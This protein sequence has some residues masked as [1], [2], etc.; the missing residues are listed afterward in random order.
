MRTSQLIPLILVTCFPGFG[1]EVSKISEL[2]CRSIIDSNLP[3]AE[4]QDYTERRVPLMPNVSTVAEWERVAREMRED[5]LKTVV[6]RGKAAEWRKLK[7][8]VEWLGEIPGG[9][10]YRIRK[11]RYEAV[12]GLWIPAVLYEPE[13]LVGKAPVSL[14]V[15]GHEGIG[16][17]VPYKQIRCINQARRG[18]IALNPEWLGMGQLR[19]TNYQHYRMNQLDLCGTSGLAPFYLAMARGLDILLA[20]K[21]ADPARVAVSGLS[22]GG[23]QTI[24][25]SSLDTRVTLANPVAGYSSFRT[26]A[27]HLSDLGDSE[28]TPCDLG[29]VTDYAHLTAMMAPRP[30][31]LTFNAKDSCCFASP[32]AIG[33]LLEAATPIFKLYGREDAL[34]VHVNFHPGDHNFGQDNREAFYRMLGTFFCSENDVYTTL[35]MPCD[36]EVKTHE[37]L[38]VDLPPNNGNFNSIALELS[39]ELPR[40]S[41]LPASKSAAERWQE[42]N[43]PRLREILRARHSRATAERVH[44]LKQDGIEAVLW[45]FRVDDQWTVP[46]IELRTSVPKGTT[47]LV[48]DHGRRS[49][50][51]EA[52]KL[53][54]DGQ[55]VLAVDP[56]Y[57][58][59]SKIRSHDFLFALLLSAVG[60]RPLGLQASQVA[61]IAQWADTH[62]GPV[63]LQ[64]VGPRASTFALA[65]AALEPKVSALRL[66]GAM[67]SLKEIIEQNGSV[68]RTPELFCFGL[69]EAFDIKHITALIAPRP[70][71]FVNASDRVKSELT[72]LTGW[73][74]IFGEQTLILE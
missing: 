40:Q 34:R 54:D 70:V 66:S 64:A 62:G 37:E 58:G 74:E 6:F 24:F 12:P 29:T 25:I 57:F 51:A 8:R 49:V 72:S 43:R 32:H 53:I 63:T 23:W 15:N 5:T 30:T 20:H 52:R 17:S 13:D 35:E 11:L 31:L 28:Q 47:I 44:T 4:I 71:R 9:S 56:F 1:S 68:D 26:R 39:R 73:Y 50:A 65:A 14:N 60:D 16:K 42:K 38:I 48:A 7:T 19:S 27:R 59:E 45:R 55:R 33:P 18:I 61:A 3:L 46:A 21:H 36:A 2:L 67:G 22:G 41:K 10:G 69:L